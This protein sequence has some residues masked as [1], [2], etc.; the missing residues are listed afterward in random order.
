[1]LSY[2]K[3]RSEAGIFIFQKTEIQKVHAPDQQQ[4][5]GIRA[6]L[7]TQAT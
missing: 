4:S 3:Q 2:L 7:C 6:R 1:M 5:I